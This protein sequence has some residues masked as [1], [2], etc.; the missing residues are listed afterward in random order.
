MKWFSGR[1]SH[2]SSDVNE[3]QRQIEELTDKLSKANGQRVYYM[4][5]RDELARHLRALE[6]YM[7][8]TVR[9]RDD[10]VKAAAA[11]NQRVT[12]LER[13]LS[14]LRRDNE[15]TEQHRLDLIARLADAT[16]APVPVVVTNSPKA[17]PPGPSALPAIPEWARADGFRFSREEGFSKLPVPETPTPPPWLLTNAKTLAEAARDDDL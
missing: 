1:G 8:R 9:E 7:L 4:D 5:D 16:A 15:T 13:T 17:L 10:A 11:A 14:V 3:L 12:D 6:S 2:R